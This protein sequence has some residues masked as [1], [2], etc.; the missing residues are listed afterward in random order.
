MHIVSILGCDLV[1]YLISRKYTITILF[2]KVVSSY[3]HL[4][5]YNV[6]ILRHLKYNGQTQ[7]HRNEKYLQV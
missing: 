1:Y 4:V 3:N 2:L 5:I 6:V 7:I